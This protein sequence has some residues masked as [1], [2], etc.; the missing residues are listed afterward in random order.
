MQANDNIRPRTAGSR[1]KSA[2]QSWQAGSGNANSGQ[3]IIDCYY[4]IE[5]DLYFQF[6]YIE[7]DF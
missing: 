4:C 7:I 6:K 1:P 3:F 2:T 5:G